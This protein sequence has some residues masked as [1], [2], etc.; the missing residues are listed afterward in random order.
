MTREEVKASRSRSLMA[1][2]LDIGGSRRMTQCKVPMEGQAHNSHGWCTRAHDDV[3]RGCT[4][5]KVP[6]ANSTGTVPFAVGART[7]CVYFEFTQVY[8]AQGKAHKTHTED[9]EKCPTKELPMVDVVQGSL[10]I[11]VQVFM[12]DSARLA[13]GSHGWR[14][15]G[16]HGRGCMWFPWNHMDGVHKDHM[17]MDVQV[18]M[19]ERARHVVPMDG[20]HKDHMDM[21]VQV[22]MNERARHHAVP[23]DGVHEDHMDV[24]VQVFM[25]ER[26]RLA[27]GSHECACTR[28]PWMAYQR[29]KDDALQEEKGPI[30]K[31]KL[32]GLVRD[33]KRECEVPLDIDV[34]VFMDERA[35][36]ARGSHGCACMRFS[37]M[38][39]ERSMDDAL[40]EEKRPIG[41]GKLGGLVRDPKRECS[42]NNSRS[43]VQVELE[44]ELEKLY[45]ARGGASQLEE[46][47]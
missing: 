7:E 46:C 19:D 34:Q 10:D 1:Q 45:S 14:T 30:G 38:T 26:A 2:T 41:K 40:Q 35:R 12:D 36:L 32:G 24:D 9:L 29:S 39:Y 11:D 37:W 4:I 31:G 43:A 28:F 16:S 18:F 21:D 13:R 42:N 3:Q 44:V 33:P 47:S 25:D 8:I 15:R 22:F 23:M 17:D 20:V 6:F 5:I 27:R